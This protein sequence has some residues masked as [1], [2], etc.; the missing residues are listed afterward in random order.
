MQV[1]NSCLFAG[2]NRNCF[3]CAEGLSLALLFLPA[4][5]LFPGAGWEVVELFGFTIDRLIVY[6]TE[7]TSLCIRTLL[8]RIIH[9]ILFIPFFTTEVL[10]AVSI[11]CHYSRDFF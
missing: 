8:Y 6:R 1:V 3:L 11:E 4:V 10:A 9:C 5:N 7:S 2:G